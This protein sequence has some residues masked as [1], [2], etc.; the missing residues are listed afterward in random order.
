MKYFEH[1]KSGITGFT[2]MKKGWKAI[3]EKIRSGSAIKKGD[4]ELFETVSSWL[5]EERDMALLLSR[6]LGLLVETG[7]RK[8]MNDLKG[9]IDHE[10]KTLLDTKSLISNLQVKG[11]ASNIKVTACFDTRM[12]QMEVFMTPPDD[13]TN[14]GKFGWIRSQI[15][16]SQKRDPENFEKIADEL[17]LYVYVKRQRVPEKISLEN[18]DDAWELF[19]HVDIKEFGLRQVKSLG[20]NFEGVQKVVTDIESMLL[21]YYKGIVQYLK[22]WVKPAPKAQKEESKTLDN[23]D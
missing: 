8:F 19:K 3:T 13:K 22:P 14:R 10:S 20:R 7:Y 16:A 12:I 1:D 2:V 4:P 5:E 6:E 17:G 15:L 11:A 9:R 23:L 18:L 21:A